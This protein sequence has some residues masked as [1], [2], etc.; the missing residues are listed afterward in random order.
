MTDS[1]GGEE[2]R[3]REKSRSVQ[4]KWH[5]CQNPAPAFHQHSTSMLLKT[6]FVPKAMP[7]FYFHEN[8]NK[9]KEQNSTI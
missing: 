8:Y 3:E 5:N 4:L 1:W 6:S 7:P 2:E 9:Y